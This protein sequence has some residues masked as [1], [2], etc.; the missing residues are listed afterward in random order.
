MGL[1]MRRRTQ[2]A[3]RRI[4]RNIP[5]IDPVDCFGMCHV[6]DINVALRDLGQARTG[7]LQGGPHMVEHDFRLPLD[8][9]RH[10]LAVFA[11]WWKSRNKNQITTRTA[12]EAWI[13]RALT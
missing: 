7:G 9:C 4:D 6:I 11:E 12:G 5:I 10:H 2:D 1:A 8:T 3:R 13:P